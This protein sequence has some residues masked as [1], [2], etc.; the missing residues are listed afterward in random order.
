MP[1]SGADTVKFLQGLNTNDVAQLSQE[2][3]DR[4]IYS[5]VLKADVSLR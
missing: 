5:F 2:P 1:I 3:G 4:G